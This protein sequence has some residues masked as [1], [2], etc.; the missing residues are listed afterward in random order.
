V[1][2]E[3]IIRRKMDQLGKHTKTHSTLG[4]QH[5]AHFVGGVRLELLPADVIGKG[6]GTA[7]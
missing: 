2:V 4:Q 6:G 1:N 7:I 5:P 3:Y